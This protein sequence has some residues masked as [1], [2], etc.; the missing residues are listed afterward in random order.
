MTAVGFNLQQPESNPMVR[1]DVRRCFPGS[2]RIVDGQS[3]TLDE[4]ER[5]VFGPSGKMPAVPLVGTNIAAE[6]FIPCRNIT[7]F[8]KDVEE[9]AVFTSETWRNDYSV[10]RFR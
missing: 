7:G 4:Y 9:E 2:C 3:V 8:S 5:A 6:A 1:L 10:S